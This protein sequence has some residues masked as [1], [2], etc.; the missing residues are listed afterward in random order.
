[1][2]T[3]LIAAGLA[4]A[5]IAAAGCGSDTDPGVGDCTTAD[6]TQ[7][8]NV[9]VELVDCEDSEAKSKIVKA[10]ADPKECGGGAV[11]FEGDK[12]C[13]EGLKGEGKAPA[14]GDCTTG[15]PEKP[16][17]INVQ[18][19]GCDD[20]KA[21]SKVVKETTDESECKSGSLTFA[22][23]KYCLEPIE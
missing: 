14:A 19:V 15:D 18:V 8:V 2:R 11:E 13:L 23:K 9:S 5:C 7:L 16:F 6:P 4:V 17:E 20:P 21:K 3:H 22:K 12:F 1:M 10:T